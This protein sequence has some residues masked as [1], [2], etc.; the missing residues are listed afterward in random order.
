[1][2]DTADLAAWQSRR[3]PIGPAKGFVPDRRDPNAPIIAL[4][5]DAVAS[6]ASDPDPDRWFPER[7]ATQHLH[8]ELKRIC[9]GCPL[10]LKCLDY[11]LKNDVI[12]FWGGTTMAQRADL[13][14]RQRIQPARVTYREWVRD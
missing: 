11:A 1:M 13:R 5:E 8:L 10:Q 4:I 2:N 6:C 7:T 12:G 3:A 14:R 9:D